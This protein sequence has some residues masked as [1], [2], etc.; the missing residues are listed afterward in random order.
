MDEIEMAVVRLICQ[1]IR[2]TAGFGL[3]GVGTTGALMAMSKQASSFS[4][5]V[6]FS[7]SAVQRLEALMR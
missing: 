6:F 7:V 4:G 3:L 2:K 5:P 1:H